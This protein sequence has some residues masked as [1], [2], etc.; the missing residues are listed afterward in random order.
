MKRSKRSRRK[1]TIT[2]DQRFVWG[3]RYLDIYYYRNGTLFDTKS[4][5]EC[6]EGWAR[7]EE[8]TIPVETHRRTRFMLHNHTG[9]NRHPVRMHQDFAGPVRT[10]FHHNTTRKVK[11]RYTQTRQEMLAFLAKYGKAI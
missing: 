5:Y 4:W 2:I 7:N 11:V 8:R 6:A 10:T 9:T 3:R 1:L